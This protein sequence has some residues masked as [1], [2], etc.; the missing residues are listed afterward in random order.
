VVVIANTEPPALLGLPRLAAWRSRFPPDRMIEGGG[1]TPSRALAELAE[2]RYAELHVHG[3]VSATVPDAAFLMMSPEADERYALTAAMIR[4]QPLRG[5]PIVVLAACHA[6]STAP[7][8]YQPWSLPAAFIDAG[9]RAVI[10]SSG[11]IEDASASE[12]FDDLRAR[13]DRGTPPPIALRDARRAWLASRPA[14][15]WVRLLMV[16]Q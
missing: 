16:F 9:A 2:A 7:N 13:L 10:A 4:K 8:L 12:F 14:D 1:A 11:V 3:M 15:A 5:R 6:A